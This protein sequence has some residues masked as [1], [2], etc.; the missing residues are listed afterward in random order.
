MPLAFQTT[1][2]RSPDRRRPALLL[3]GVLCGFLAVN[4]A[5]ARQVEITVLHTTDLHGHILPGT[6]Y[7]ARTNVGGLLRCSTLIQKLRSERPNTLLIDCGDLYQGTAE[8]YLSEGRVMVR[9]LDWLRYDA[10]ILG[11]HEFDWGLTTMKRLVASSS[12]PVLAANLVSLPNRPHPFP[13][14]KPYVIRHVDGIKVAIVGLITPGVPR[15]STPDQFGDAIFEPS[16][17]ALKRVL[18]LVREESPDVLLLATHQGCKVRGDDHANEVNA[19]AREF[20]EFDAIIGGHTHQAI[21]KM[22]IHDR[23]L[24]TQ[25]GYYGAWLGELNLT[26]D[27]VA[28][29]VV[30]KT[31]QLHDVDERVERD[32]ALEA[33][34]AKEIKRAESYMAQTVGRAADTITWAV[35]EYGNS[36]IQALIARALTKASGAQLVLHGVLAEEELRPGVLQMADLWRVVPYENRIAVFHVTPAELLEI[37]DEN[38]SAPSVTSL[39]GLHGA[40]YE[41]K[42]TPDGTR[43]AANLV[44][45]DGTIPHPRKRLRLAVNSFSVASGGGRYKRLRE[46][47]ERP[48]SR[49]KILNLDT[50]AAVLDYVK[51]HSPLTVASLLEK[52]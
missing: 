52:P 34:F 49:L 27:T 19:I 41:W 13:S 16:V 42:V 47:A 39:M 45:S 17:D 43:R 7:N 40:R 6:D 29:R 15:W 50:R 32:P 44:L 21:P 22:W 5:E 26:Y 25:A 20:P 8:S 35:D 28:R 38:A 36:P 48:E 9:A 23:V 30:L 31:A 51:R 37:L 11:N 14:V 1:T 3:F 18:P 12:T 24:Y 46:I 10:W 4:A 2:S 33:E